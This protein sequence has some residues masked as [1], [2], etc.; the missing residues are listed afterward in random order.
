MHVRVSRWRKHF[1]NNRIS[2]EL[3]RVLAALGLDATTMDA[4]EIKS[5]LKRFITFLM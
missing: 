4:A 5:T 1:P 2:D 3:A